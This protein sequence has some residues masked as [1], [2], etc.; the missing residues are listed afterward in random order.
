MTLSD[1]HEAFVTIRDFKKAV[2]G[3]TLDPDFLNIIKR[4]A[5]ETFHKKF[6]ITLPNKLHI[7]V[8][9]VPEYILENKLALGQTSD[10]VIEATHQFVNKRL[11]GSRYWVNKTGHS[12]G[13][14]TMHPSCK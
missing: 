14:S 1:F 8:S 13:L 12:Q 5:F 9:H 10:Q 7:T 6:K 3:S 4:V 11:Q 2:C